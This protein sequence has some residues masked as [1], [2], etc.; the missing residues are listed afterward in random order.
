M[1]EFSDRR[2]LAG[3]RCVDGVTGLSIVDPFPISTEQLQIRQNF[4]G[5]YAVLDGP[6]LHPLT[7]QLRPSTPWPAPAAFEIT[8]ED[9]QHRYLPRRSQIQTPQAP[10]V[11][12][13]PPKGLMVPGPAA[14]VDLD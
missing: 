11:S 7:G 12:S 5:V 14:D 9:P 8:I 3:F 10:D 6:G 1:N 4:S 13:A 2:V